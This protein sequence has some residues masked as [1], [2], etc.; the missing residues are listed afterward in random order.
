MAGWLANRRATPTNS[1]CFCGADRSINHFS[2]SLQRRLTATQGRHYLF[3]SPFQLLSHNARSCTL[4]SAIA[5]QMMNLNFRLIWLRARASGQ[6]QIWKCDGM[7]NWPNITGTQIKYF[8]FWILYF[9]FFLSYAHSIC[10]CDYLHILE[11]FDSVDSSEKWR[12]LSVA[13]RFICT[14]CARETKCG[15]KV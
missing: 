12:L 2:A 15:R 4:A 8:V 7:L 1:D 5:H 6:R 14:M 13:G 10:N 3:H 11:I 9:F